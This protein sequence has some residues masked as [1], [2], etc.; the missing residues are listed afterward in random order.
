MYLS[1][2]SALIVLLMSNW[3]VYTLS[4]FQVTEVVVFFRCSNIQDKVAVNTNCFLFQV[5][6]HWGSTCQEFCFYS[7][8]VIYG[9]IKFILEQLS[10]NTYLRIG[11]TFPVSNNIFYF[12]THPTLGSHTKKQIVVPYSKRMMCLCTFLTSRLRNP[13]SWAEVTWG[14]LSNHS[15]AFPSKFL[16]VLTDDTVNAPEQRARM[17]ELSAHQF[18]SING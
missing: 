7:P 4:Y 15:Q 2:G 5:S 3:N 12:N 9:F 13:P 6:S 17:T 8:Q 16:N 14:E 11:I 10:C 18:T 1:H